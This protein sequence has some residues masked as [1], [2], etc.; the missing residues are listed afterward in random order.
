VLCAEQ[1]WR[2]NLISAPQIKD[3]V[4]I[5]SLKLLNN[6][7]S[8]QDKFTVNEEIIVQIQFEVKQKS[9]RVCVRLDLSS[10][11]GVKLFST[12]DS[13]SNLSDC[14]RELGVYTETLVIPK[15]FLN[16]GQFLISIIITDLDTIDQEI[17]CLDCLSMKIIDDQMPFGVRGNWSG[18]WPS[19]LL[20]PNLVWNVELQ[21]SLEDLASEEE[22]NQELLVVD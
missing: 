19:S 4:Q 18:P 16:E 8:I 22:N 20:R 11:E 13:L 17:R 6:S 10:V 12:M 21:K 1:N 3:R 14:R 7:G 15:E 5:Y 2:D 9:S